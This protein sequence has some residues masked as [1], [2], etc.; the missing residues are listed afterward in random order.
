MA[1]AV[2]SCWR[3]VRAKPMYRL[4]RR[5]KRRVPCERLLSTP[6]NTQIKDLP[7]FPHDKP[8]HQTSHSVK[9]ILDNSGLGD[10]PMSTPL[11]LY[12][13][14]PAIAFNTAKMLIG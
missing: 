14:L 12:R 8:T 3:C 1:V 4:R 2:R 10:D 5:S 9:I 6:C 11:T 7:I 13:L